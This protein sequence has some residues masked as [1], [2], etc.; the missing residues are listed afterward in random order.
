MKIKRGREWPPWHLQ[1]WPFYFIGHWSVQLWVE[2]WS[3]YHWICWT[4]N[5]FSVPTT[6]TIFKNGPTICLFCLFQSFSEYNHKFSLQFEAKLKKRRC[7]VW[8]STHGA[9]SWKMKTNW[10]SYGSP[11]FGTT[12]FLKNGLTPASISLM[13]GLFQ[14][15]NTIFTTNK[16]K[17]CPSSLLCRDLNPEPLEQ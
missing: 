9:A 4:D 15:N 8:E 12:F 2:P 5:G 6:T 16:C 10:L 3:W 1:K 13:F 7:W 17:K 11:P 14:T